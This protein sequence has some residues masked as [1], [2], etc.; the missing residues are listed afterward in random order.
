MINSSTQM[1]WGDIAVD[2]QT[3]PF[4]IQFHLKVSKCD[5]FGAGAYVVVGQM[6]CQ[7]CLVQAPLQYIKIHVQ[8]TSSG[9]FLDIEQILKPVRKSW[10]VSKIREVLQLLRLPQ[11][12]F[13]GHSF[14]IG[15]ATTAAATAGVQDS[16][17]QTVGRWH[18]AALLCYVRTPKEQLAAISPMR[19]QTTQSAA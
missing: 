7:L 8:G 15:A 11:H 13:A 2:S 18:S 16:M 1:S 17:I 14:Q 5:Q 4:M 3:A 6:G 9:P 12:Q 19:A 10:F